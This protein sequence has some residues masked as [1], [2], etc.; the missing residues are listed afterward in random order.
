MPR[1]WLIMSAVVWLI[2]IAIYLAWILVPGVGD[3]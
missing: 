2:I 3:H 1:K